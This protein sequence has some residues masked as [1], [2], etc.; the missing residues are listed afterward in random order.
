MQAGREMVSGRCGLRGG[1]LCSGWQLRGA[2]IWL[3]VF[4]LLCQLLGA[5]GMARVEVHGGAGAA[6]WIDPPPSV[7][8]LKVS[9]GVCRGLLLDLART[10]PRYGWGR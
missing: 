3:L 6:A 8:V 2:P 7:L 9:K 4:P 1:G 10:L 5:Q